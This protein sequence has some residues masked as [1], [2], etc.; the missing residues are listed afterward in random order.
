MR[1]TILG[2]GKVATRLGLRLFQKGITISQ[3]YSRNEEHARVLA[4]KLNAAFTNKLED[5]KAGADLYLFAVSDDAIEELAKKLADQK[6]HHSSFVVHTSGATPST[7]FKNSFKR[8]GVFYPLQSF[9]EEVEPQWDKIPICIDASNLTDMHNLSDL[10]HKCSNVVEP[11]TDEKRAGLHVAAV[12]ANN[13]TNHMLHLSSEITRKFGVPFEI[14][15]PLIQETIRKI[16]KG[17]PEEMQTGPAIRGDQETIQRHL[18][19]LEDWPDI[20]MVYDLITKSI[21]KNTLKK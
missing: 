5:V 3:V 14:L 16:E 8:Y 1:I 21:H 7:V 2:S 20:Q 19:L 12:F 17:T 11:L 4:G 13:F 6:G 9:S 10:A 15:F 18:R